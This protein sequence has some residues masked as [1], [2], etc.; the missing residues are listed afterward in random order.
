MNSSWR[1]YN[2]A[3][4][5]SFP[6]HKEVK[7]SNI[8]RKIFK[9]Q[10]FF[11]R[12]VSDFD[13]KKEMSF[14]YVVKDGMFNVESLTSKVRNQVRKG[15]KNCVVRKIF[16]EELIKKGYNVY[17]HAF[18]KYNTFNVPQNEVQFKEKI[19][20]LSLDFEFWGV[21]NE[22]NKLIGYSQNR[23]IFN[24]CEFSVTKFL[25]EYLRLRPSEALFYSMIDF[26]INERKV[27]YI[28]NGTRS[29]SH[30]TN[31]QDFLI[32]KFR[33]RKA[34][35]R[36]H[37]AYHPLVRVLVWLMFPF[38]FLFKFSR[39]RILRKIGVVLFQE[40]LRRNCNKKDS[41]ASNL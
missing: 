34:F 18:K 20:A 26:Y 4:I 33:F 37:I 36:L 39:I 15:L 17:I 8:T 30:H 23:I 41:N 24:V 12:W 7:D 28:H 11:A 31:I 1:K 27:S 14:W 16:K 38:R 6:P 32:K 29:I 21:F 9:S 35:C 2:G 40:E 3:I 19:D 25:P 5:S 22:R 13:C 10:V